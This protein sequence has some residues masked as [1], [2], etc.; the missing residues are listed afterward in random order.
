MCIRDRVRS[1]AARGLGLKLLPRA[2]RA[3]PRQEAGDYGSEHLA[4]HFSGW[5]KRARGPKIQHEGA[6]VP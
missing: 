4:G 2:K 3:S 6:A 5:S 1:P